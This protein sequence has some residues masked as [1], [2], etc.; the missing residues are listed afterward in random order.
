MFDRRKFIFGAGS[1]ARCL[2]YAKPSSTASST[3][4]CSLRCPRGVSTPPAGRHRYFFK[5]Y[6]LGTR[7]P[8]LHR[9]TKADLEREM[10]GHVLVQLNCSAYRKQK[11]EPGEA[12]RARA[13]RLAHTNGTTTC[14][15]ESPMNNWPPTTTRAIGTSSW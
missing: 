10:Q 6:A 4:P 12:I 15:T 2:L 1:R 8:G 11:E 14:Q 13:W 9:P 3:P 5:L 7:L